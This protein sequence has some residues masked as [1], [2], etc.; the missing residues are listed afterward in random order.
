VLDALY[1]L[2]LERDK[3]KHLRSNN[4]SA[5]I[6]ETLQ[7]RLGRVDIKTIQTCPGSA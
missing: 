7:D 5:F 2:L 6:A 1:P 4:G 3:P